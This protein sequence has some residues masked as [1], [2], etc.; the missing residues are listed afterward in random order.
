MSTKSTRKIINGKKIIEEIDGQKVV[1]TNKKRRLD[2]DN[3]VNKFQRELTSFEGEKKFFGKEL[4]FMI[5]NLDSDIFEYKK[6]QRKISQSK[7]SQSQESSNMITKHLP[8]SL[9]I[10]SEK[11]GKSQ[12]YLVSESLDSSSSDIFSS[13]DSI[14][15]DKMKYWSDNTEES[16]T[17]QKSISLFKMS[18]LSEDSFES[19]SFSSFIKIDEEVKEF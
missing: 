13:Q 6:K 12:A 7:I 17:T 14:N 4:D 5:K 16:F 8:S 15:Y 3:K 19:E 9:M 18:D 11:E 1:L 10:I 2:L